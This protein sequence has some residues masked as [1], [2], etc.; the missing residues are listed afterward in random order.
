MP[1]NILDNPEKA[2]LLAENSEYLR[3]GSEHTVE[4]EMVTK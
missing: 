4:R 1:E 3:R 2:R